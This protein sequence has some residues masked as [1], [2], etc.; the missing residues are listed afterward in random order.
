MYQPDFPISPCSI[1]PRIAKSAVKGHF[2][3][4]GVVCAG[5]LQRFLRRP[6]ERRSPPAF[7]CSRRCRGAKSGRNTGVFRKWVPTTAIIKA[8]RVPAGWNSRATPGKKATTLCPTN[9]PL[10]FRRSSRP[11]AGRGLF[12]IA[13][14]A[15]MKCP[16]API[17]AIFSFCVIQKALSFRPEPANAAT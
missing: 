17:K 5:M 15:A 16:D 13:S 6:R 1:A 4:I 12:R 10:H 2:Q 7:H 3:H 9:P 8:L 11:A 14:T